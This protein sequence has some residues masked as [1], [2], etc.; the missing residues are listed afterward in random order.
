M[1]DPNPEP[2]HFFDLF[3][4][5]PGPSKSWSHNTLKVRAV[6]NFKSIPY[7]QSWISYPDIKPLIISLG[8]PPNT[9]GR[10]YTLPAIIHKASIT[11]NANGAMMDSLPI[12]THLDTVFPSPPL[13]PSGDASY[14]IF[15]A[16]G[17]II[18][19]LGPVLRSFIVPRVPGHLDERG[20]VY[21]HETR[22]VAFGRPLSEVRPT[23]KAELE[24]LWEVV[25]R[26]GPVLVEMLR[27][28]EGKEERGP[29]FEGEKPGYADLVVACELAF[30][31]RFDKELFGRFLALGNGEVKRLYE[32]CLPWLEGQGVGDR[33]WSIP[34][35]V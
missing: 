28:R 23:E 12:V 9:A 29:F 1:A 27:G 19:R 14:V 21:F 31:E 18:S 26:E 13:F 35:G 4:D 7:T 3:S 2:V 6:L 5:L 8:L 25:E 22:A 34:E 15:V 16:V 20:S 17:R 30:M 33:E 11:S 10:P 32:A 24:G